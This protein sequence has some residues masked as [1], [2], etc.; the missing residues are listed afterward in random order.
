MYFAALLLLGH[1]SGKLFYA[2]KYPT[3]VCVPG[4]RVGCGVL[5]QG[6]HLRQSV[7]QHGQQLR[8]VPGRVCWPPPVPRA[9]RHGNIRLQRC[10]GQGYQV[11]QLGQHD[12]VGFE[13]V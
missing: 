5:R 10:T 3:Q 13:G 8:E 11:R 1:D 6:R 7:H 2:G 9:R 4:E 12:P